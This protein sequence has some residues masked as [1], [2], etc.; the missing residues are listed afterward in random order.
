MKNFYYLVFFLALVFLIEW[1]GSWLTM[2]SVNDWYTTLEKPFWTPPSWVFAPAWTILYIMIAI[3]GWLI[4]VRVKPS[5]KKTIALNIFYIQLLLNL[6]WSYFFFY[7][8]SPSIALIDLTLLITAVIVNTVQFS[9]LYRL[10]GLMLI[11][12]VIW[13]L[14]AATLNFSIAWNL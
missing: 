1:G 13:L 4:F 2:S 6:M 7:L 12:Y 5:R 9:N 14:F 11:P 3:S 8:K 10:A